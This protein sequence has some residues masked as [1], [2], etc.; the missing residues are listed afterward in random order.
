MTDVKQLI[1]QLK[2]SAIDA[3]AS[4][5]RNGCPSCGLDSNLFSEAGDTLAAQQERIEALKA[6]LEPLVKE[7]DACGR[8]VNVRWIP[9]FDRAR[10]ALKGGDE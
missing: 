7:A 2:E 9:L 10:A 1:E 5:L 4:S 6:A 8:S 3:S